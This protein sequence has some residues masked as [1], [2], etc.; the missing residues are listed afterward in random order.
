MAT[1]LI[2][3]Q[4]I[5]V[6]TEHSADAF[7]FRQ[8]VAELCSG[9]LLPAIEKLFDAKAPDGKLI[10]AEKLVIDVGDLPKEKW[11]AVFVDRVLEELTKCIS[12]AV[13]GLSNKSLDDLNESRSSPDEDGNILREISTEENL[14][15]S[16]LYFLKNGTLPWFSF[17]KSRDTLN[18][19]ISQ[20]LA[21]P[22]FISAL[23]NLFH[24]N[25]S[26]GQRLVFQFN[27]S[28]T[29]SFIAKCGIQKELLATL[30]SFWL[31][32][33]E[34]IGGGRETG[35]RNILYAALINFV[36]KEPVRAFRHDMMMAL[37]ENVFQQIPG[38]DKLVVHTRIAGQVFEYDGESCPMTGIGK[39]PEDDQ[40]ISLSSVSGS[41][42]KVW[43]WLWL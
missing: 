11:E 7:A 40:K 23:R 28:I 22:D 18:D 17:V 36:S 16:V 1:H 10:H 39:D 35:E 9:R 5:D 27:E 33:L 20:L 32:F 37:L 14:K 26:A 12:T 19:A 30:K 8:H 6:T 42:G 24:E 29:E 43:L 31:P 25:R 15:N 4:F 21:R 2:Q 38:S 3:R 13:P 41:E 34:G